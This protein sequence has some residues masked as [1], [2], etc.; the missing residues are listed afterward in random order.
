MLNATSPGG[1]VGFTAE[2][3]VDMTRRVTGCYVSTNAVLPGAYAVS[4]HY[5]AILIDRKVPGKRLAETLLAAMD[6]FI[7]GPRDVHGMD[8]QPFALPV[9]RG[10]AKKGGSRFIRR[11]KPA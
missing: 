4:S 1:E 11:F 7:S 2:Q 6:H 10:P 8:T 5:N 3:L 9:A